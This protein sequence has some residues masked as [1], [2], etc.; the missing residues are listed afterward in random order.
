MTVT[1]PKGLGTR[2]RRLWR[3]VTT[4][5]EMGPGELELLVEACRVADLLEDPAILADPREA[6]QQRELFGRLIGRLSL[7]EPE[8]AAATQ[9]GRR[10]AAVRWGYA[11]PKLAKGA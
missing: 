1:A 11:R 3:R 4:D 10:G 5:W 6:R 2:G 7:E 9:L 8:D